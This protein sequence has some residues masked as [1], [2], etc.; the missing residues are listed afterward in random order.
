MLKKLREYKPPK[1][2]EEEKA[3][4]EQ[5]GIPAKVVEKKPGEPTRVITVRIPRSMHD[6]LKVEAHEHNTSMNKLCISKLLQFADRELVPIEIP[7]ETSPME[8]AEAIEERDG[9]RGDGD[10]GIATIRTVGSGPIS[11]VLYP[12]PATEAAGRA[13]AISL[14]SRLLGPSSS[15]PEG[16][17]PD[18]PAGPPGQLVCRGASRRPLFDLA[19]GGVCLAKLVAQP[20]GELLPRRFTLTARAEAFA[21]VCFLLHFP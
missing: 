8:G 20:A 7:E 11:R 1:L 15:L 10:F 19:P 16:F 5:E 12:S 21:A 2:T 14:G 18:Q 6:A 3:K 9:A 13:M 4:A 17:G